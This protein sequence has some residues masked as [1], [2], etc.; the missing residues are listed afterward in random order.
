MAA[1]FHLVTRSCRKGTARSA[2]QIDQGVAQK[3]GGRGGGA[4]EPV[5]EKHEGQPSAD[6][7]DISQAHPPESA[8]DEPG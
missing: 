3:G 1:M 4:G 2:T 5:E 7:A 8:T 6:D